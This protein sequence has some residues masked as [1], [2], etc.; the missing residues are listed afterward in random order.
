MAEKFQTAL[1][2]KKHHGDEGG[3][4]KC[5]KEIDVSVTQLNVRRSKVKFCKGFPPDKESHKCHSPM[6]SGQPGVGLVLFLRSA[7]ETK[8][9][10]VRQ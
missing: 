1:L 10:V 5:S 7:F 9:D 3:A 8:I 6:R 4:G 2:N